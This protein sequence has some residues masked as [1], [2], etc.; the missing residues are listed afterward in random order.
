M[1]LDAL[2]AG[3]YTGHAGTPVGFSST[4]LDSLDELIVREA[5]DNTEIK[6]KRHNLNQEAANQLLLDGVSEKDILEQYP[7]VDIEQS[8]AKLFYA[9]MGDAKSEA[10]EMQ[11]KADILGIFPSPDTI[12]MPANQ[13][14]KKTLMNDGRSYYGRHNNKEYKEGI[15]NFDTLMKFGGQA[16]GASGEI[17]RL[18]AIQMKR[19]ATEKLDA[20]ILKNHKRLGLDGAIEQGVLDITAELEKIQTVDDLRN[21]KLSLIH[22]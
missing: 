18:D 8:V 11:Y 17:I 10:E 16:V 5:A 13:E 7:D 15:E 6:R 20:Y 3:S 2:K 14:L 4:K 12:V 1:I 19:I 21:H 22:I 9:K